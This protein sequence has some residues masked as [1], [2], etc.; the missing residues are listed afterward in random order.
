[1]TGGATKTVLSLIAVLVLCSGALFAGGCRPLEPA[2]PTFVDMELES[3]QWPIVREIANVPVAPQWTADGELIVFVVDRRSDFIARNFVRNENLGDHG[4]IFV[5]AAD[6]SAVQQLSPEDEEGFRHYYFS[7]TISPG[8]SQ[9][10]F[11]T[12]RYVAQVGSFFG[13]SHYRR[14]FEIE[15]ANLDG[16]DPL[17][18]TITAP[19][20]RSD[21]YNINVAPRWSPDGSKL[22]YGRG[23]FGTYG[24]YEPGIHTINVDG[25]GA[26]RIMSF[27][28]FGVGAP[29]LHNGLVWS[30]SGEY[31]VVVVRQYPHMPRPYEVPGRGP[32]SGDVTALYVVS[33]DG[34]NPE[35]LIWAAE[36]FDSGSTLWGHALSAPAW[37]L[38]SN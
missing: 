28:H 12:S 27:D 31:L 2:V 21:P 32:F 36:L 29:R 6:G 11:S 14:H 38:D 33:S 30:P 5:A 37:T 26:K 8:G 18:L 35:P 4:R 17:R 7:P 15:I 34:G 22:G 16:S 10:A 9:I 3:P 24:K 20:Q 23:D 13:R 1:M 19:A 25:T